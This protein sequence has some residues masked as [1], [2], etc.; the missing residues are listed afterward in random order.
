MPYFESSSYLKFMKT[1]KILTWNSDNDASW[2]K[3]LERSGFTVL[4]RHQT[5]G[6]GKGE[7]GNS[8]C[9]A[10]TPRAFH[11]RGSKL[12]HG[13]VKE[14]SHHQFKPWWRFNA[15]LNVWNSFYLRFQS[16]C[17]RNYALCLYYIDVIIYPIESHFT[18]GKTKNPARTQGPRKKILLILHKTSQRVSKY[19][20]TIFTAY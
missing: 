13:Q 19:H 8:E 1:F 10:L 4:P 2:I 3:I 7:G 11:L 14:W 16:D 18:K 12:T 20:R 15:N 9:G 5:V 6:R 17:V